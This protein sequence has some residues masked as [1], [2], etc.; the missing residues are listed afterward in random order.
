MKYRVEL[1]FTNDNVLGQVDVEASSKI[2]AAEAARAAAH[3]APVKVLSVDPLNE[4]LKPYPFKGWTVHH[5]TENTEQFI[6]C[7]GGQVLRADTQ[8]EIEALI[9]IQRECDECLC[10]GLFD[11]CEKC[12]ARRRDC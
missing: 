5:Y 12:I 9:E 7:R 2:G 6:A 1:R 4:R 3:P 10:G 8:P 11:T